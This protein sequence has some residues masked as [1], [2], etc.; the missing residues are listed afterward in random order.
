[1]PQ[2]NYTVPGNIAGVN[3]GDRDLCWLA[4]TAVLYTWKNGIPCTMTQAANRLGA[5]FVARQAAGT[6]LRYNELTLWRTRGLFDMQHQ[7]CIGAQGWDALLRAH[8]QI[9]RAHV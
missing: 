9:G 4:A 7:Q 3:Q 6:A 5:E 8:G 1:M 2:L